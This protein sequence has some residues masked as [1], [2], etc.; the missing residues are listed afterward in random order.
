MLHSE[1][2]QKNKDADLLAIGTYPKRFLSIFALT[3]F[4][5]ATFSSILFDVT[6]EA[7]K[8]SISSSSSR[9]FPSA[10]SSKRKIVFL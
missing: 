7:L 2:R 3:L 8:V 9:I 1:E 5:T 4:A 10:A 6:L